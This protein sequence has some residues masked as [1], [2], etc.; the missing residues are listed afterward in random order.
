S[1]RTPLHLACVKG[2]DKIVQCLLEYNAKVNIVDQNNQTPLMKAIEGGHLKCV[3]LLLSYRADLTVRDKHGNA[4][5][6][7]AVK[8]GRKDIIEL[9]LRNGVSIN[10]HNQVVLSPIKQSSNKLIF[11]I[12]GLTP[13]HLAVEYHNL[14]LLQYLVQEGA[15]LD[16]TDVTGRHVSALMMACES[17]DAPI[18]EML[19]NFGASTDIRNNDG[20]TAEEIAKV[21]HHSRCFKLLHSLR[22]SVGRVPSTEGCRL[23]ESPTF[24]RSF[25]RRGH[26]VK[27][28]TASSGDGGGGGSGEDTGD[29]ILE[30]VFESSDEESKDR[31]ETLL[32]LLRET[33]SSDEAVLERTICRYNSN[34]P[35][36]SST[37]LT[38][39]N[40]KLQP[41]VD[42]MGIENCK[43]PITLMTETTSQQEDSWNSDSSDAK[44]EGGIRK[45][46]L[47]AALSAKL[48]NQTNK[49]E[50]EV[51][52]SSPP[53]RPAE[54]AESWV[55]GGSTDRKVGPPTEKSTSPNEDCA[56]EVAKKVEND[57]R[58]GSD[59]PWDSTE[60]EEDDKSQVAICIHPLVPRDGD[61]KFQKDSSQSESSLWDSEVED[62]EVREVNEASV[63]TLTQVS[64]SSEKDLSII[65]ELSKVPMTLGTGSP[66]AE[67]ANR[68][69]ASI[70]QVL[71]NEE[72]QVHLNST[73]DLWPIDEQ[74]SESFSVAS[75]KSALSDQDEKQASRNYAIQP[76]IKSPLSGSPSASSSRSKKTDPKKSGNA[77]EL[78]TSESDETA[79]IPMLP[80]HSPT[81]PLNQTP[82]RSD[83]IKPKISLTS[84]PCGANGPISPQ[85]RRSR[86]R[87]GKE[88]SQSQHMLSP[89]APSAGAAGCSINHDE[90]PVT[91]EA[92]S[93]QYQLMQSIE[94]LDREESAHKALEEELNVAREELLTSTI[95]Y[96]EG[97]CQAAAQSSQ[98]FADLFTKLKHLEANLAEESNHRRRLESLEQLMKSQLAEKDEKLSRVHS[99]CQDL[100]AELQRVKK[101]LRE[102]VH[103]K[104]QTSCERATQFASE[105]VLIT[106][107]VMRAQME[108]SRIR[109]DLIDSKIEVQN[110]MDAIRDD[111][112]RL[113][114]VCLERIFLTSKSS[115]LRN[116]EEEN[117]RLRS[118][119][120]D[121]EQQRNEEVAKY[122]EKMALIEEEVFSLRKSES[123]KAELI[124]ENKTKALESS[125]Q[126]E[127]DA[128][129]NL[130]Q[131]LI[132]AGD[133]QSETTNLLMESQKKEENVCKWMTRLYKSVKSLGQ[134]SQALHAHLKVMFP[135]E[136]EDV[137]PRLKTLSGEEMATAVELLDALDSVQDAAKACLIEARRAIPDLESAEREMTE[138]SVQTLRMAKLPPNLDHAQSVEKYLVKRILEVKNSEW[139]ARQTVEQQKEEISRLNALNSIANKTRTVATNTEYSSDVDSPS[140]QVAPRTIT[141]KTSSPIGSFDN[142]TT[143]G[144][145]TALCAPLEASQADQIAFEQL[146]EENKRL[147]QQLAH[148]KPRKKTANRHGGQLSE[149]GSS[150]IE[151]IKGARR[152]TFR[153][154]SHCCRTG[155]HMSSKEE[156]DVSTCEKLQRRI[157]ELELERNRI[158]VEKQVLEENARAEHRLADKLIT[159]TLRRRRNRY[160]SLRHRSGRRNRRT[161]RESSYASDA[162]DAS[163]TS[164]EQHVKRR[165]GHRRGGPKSTPKV[166]EDG[167]SENEEI[168]AVSVSDLQPYKSNI[169]PK[170]CLLAGDC[171][172]VLLVFHTFMHEA[173][174]DKTNSR[175]LHRKK[176]FGVPS[177]TSLMLQ[178]ARMN[179]QAVERDLLSHTTIPD[180]DSSDYLE[181]LKK[182]YLI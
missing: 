51:V 168:C 120:R 118:A 78:N 18:T 154:P 5:I 34:L 182:K 25:N 148:S 128:V 52:V 85:P 139:S 83:C 54:D 125:L 28:N 84:P 122:E 178:K 108:L 99:T 98:G 19:I 15:E 109:N 60:N 179:L 147:Q 37:C 39:R 55:D 12:N 38:N 29:D 75:K 49:M 167:S 136:T 175:D 127:K 62:N 111:L 42:K 44:N 87:N 96:R 180:V 43:P 48:A 80:N 22:E 156:D 76:I 40:E 153:Q 134:S 117:E 164:T 150:E 135:T 81:P 159:Q 8:F 4:P 6:H 170:V 88:T 66:L 41:F 97:S 157:H 121:L 35:T 59:S 145:S 32:S 13:L 50:T 110:D 68:A 70:T 137:V 20:L 61:N 92:E 56:P 103:A 79:S 138:L 67:A 72:N 124:S 74:S 105:N 177:V 86:S 7:Q 115:K 27:R 106:R 73:R 17:G 104:L 10:T 71:Q 100:D 151:S 142:N 107:L 23:A 14:P 26:F 144:C 155:F 172:G 174:A 45:V 119:K 181:Y 33:H 140:L 149:S 95:A 162:S 36:R 176:I 2:D 165:K 102:V 64:E 1:S 101:D 30:G 173:Y 82:S 9:F 123:E 166:T 93:L 129:K 114:G 113:Q 11:C 65:E 47:V 69:A 3:N 94:A 146:R 171:I 131:N 130:E 31:S 112:T 158:L 16:C 116:L 58:R 163:A 91:S 53:N 21:N 89:S 57:E 77:S 160:S 63:S 161:R 46:N 24:K 141:A 169:R 143:T 132:R 126:K 133:K 152:K 90:V